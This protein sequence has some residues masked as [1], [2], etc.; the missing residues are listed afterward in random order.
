[1]DFDKFGKQLK[2][3]PKKTLRFVAGFSVTLIV[4]WLLVLMQTN[5]WKNEGYVDMK[6]LEKISENQGLQIAMKS[7]SE[8]T[9]PVSEQRSSAPGYGTVLFL[10]LAVGGAYYFLN[11]K[12]KK[13]PQDKSVSN[14]EIL[15]T[16]PVSGENSLVMAGVNEEY[17]IMS[18]GESGLV[19]LKVFSRSEWQ[20][21]DLAG[22]IEPV[23]KTNFAELLKGFQKNGYHINDK[24][25]LKNEN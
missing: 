1:M 5:S 12:S 21:Q 18:S 10:L 11:N 4:L 2:S 17:W 3:N 23:K 8:S 24:A 6:N 22:Q 25:T 7:K 14:I 13:R 15:E 20:Q 9:Q 16:I 19:I